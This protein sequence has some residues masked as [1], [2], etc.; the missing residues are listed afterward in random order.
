[1]QSLAPYTL[2]WLQRHLHPVGIQ[3]GHGSG[4]VWEKGWDADSI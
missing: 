1:M 4:S 3:L 2:H